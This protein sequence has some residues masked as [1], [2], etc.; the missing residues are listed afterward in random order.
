MAKLRLLKTSPAIWFNKI[1]RRKQ[2]SPS[3]INCNYSEGFY[4]RYQQ[5]PDH[6]CTVLS[7]DRSMRLRDK[8]SPVLATRLNRL[9]TLT[10]SRF[11]GLK[12]MQPQILYL[13]QARTEQ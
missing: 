7:P 8:P 13:L 4:G 5:Y 10:F 1:C 11:S 12:N 6:Y 2:L 9:L 3:S